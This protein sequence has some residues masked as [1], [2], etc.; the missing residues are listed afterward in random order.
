MAKK[1]VD[2]RTVTKDHTV[3]PTIANASYMRE[4]R[5]PGITEIV[6]MKGR[7][8]SLVIDKRWR[9]VADTALGFVK[10]FA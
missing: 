8:H 5:N 4:K 2:D 3:P 6:E 7:G 9:E 10:R 1:A